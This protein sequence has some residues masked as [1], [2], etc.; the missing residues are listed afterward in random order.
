M[1]GYYTWETSD[2][3]DIT[4]E[5]LVEEMVGH[6]VEDLVWPRYRLER[7]EDLIQQ[8]IRQGGGSVLLLDSF[9]DQVQHA[10]VSLALLFGPV[11][12]ARRQQLLDADPQALTAIYGEAVALAISNAEAWLP[13]E[14]MRAGHGLEQ[15]HHHG[16][17]YD[18]R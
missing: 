7:Y 10:S 4:A 9:R 11:L 2:M 18:G 6:A 8:Y 17:G 3:G 13:S 15:A 12:L 1:A 16:G 14:G 5:Q